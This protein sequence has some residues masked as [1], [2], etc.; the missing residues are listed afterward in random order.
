MSAW[1]GSIVVPA[2]AAGRLDDHV[3]LAARRREGW[4]VDR[5]AV[6]LGADRRAVRQA[7]A[8][9]G[10]PSKLSTMRFPALYDPLWVRREIA[11]TS[12][13]DVPRRL[14]ASRRSVRD[15][16]RRAGITPRAT[17]VV[18]PDRLA[19][20]TWLRRRLPEQATYSAIA[21]E[22]NCSDKAVRRAV[23]RHGLG[24]LARRRRRFPQLYEPGWVDAALATRTG[25]D[26]AA[27]LGCS[28]AAVFAARRYLRTGIAHTDT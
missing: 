21:A 13:A 28:H 5:I 19:D 20:P 15:A 14:G 12:I 7:L 1:Q 18:S 26:I 22:L 24:S 3:W 6:E 25:R 9:A 27:E 17:S 4:S 8:A 11:A 16:A 2:P 23:A 10:L